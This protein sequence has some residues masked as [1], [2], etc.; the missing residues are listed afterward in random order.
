MSSPA[1][2]PRARTVITLLQKSEGK[3]TVD[4]I[5]ALVT[6]TIV[7]KTVTGTYDGKELTA[8]G[9]AFASDNKYYTQDKVAFSG[10]SKVARTD[11]GKT[12]M[13]L[14]GKFANADTNNFTNV[15]FVVTDGYVDIAKAD[16]TLK[17]PTSPNPTTA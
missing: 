11:A 2:R 10:D 6:V 15:T 9:Y 7:G 3:L 4:P 5:T 14:P 12:E 17:P 1:A 8:E 13:G 16:V